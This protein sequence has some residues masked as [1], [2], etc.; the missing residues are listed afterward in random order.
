MHLAPHP[1]LPQCLPERIASNTYCSVSGIK[2]G[3]LKGILHVGIMAHSWRLQNNGFLF[4]PIFP[5]GKTLF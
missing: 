3:L 1:W 4:Y 2:R 5:F